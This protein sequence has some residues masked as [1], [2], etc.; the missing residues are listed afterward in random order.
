MKHELTVANAGH[1]PL[2]VRQP[3]GT[4]GDLMVVLQ[5]QLPKSIDDESKTLIEQFTEKNPMSVRQG[6]SF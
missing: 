2:V 1:L 4:A 6:L 5:I 3:D